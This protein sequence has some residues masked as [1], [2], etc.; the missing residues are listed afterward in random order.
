MTNNLAGMLTM[1]SWSL[2]VG[3]D[4]LRW[5]LALRQI[6]SGRTSPACFVPKAENLLVQ[7]VFRISYSVKNFE[8]SQNKNYLVLMECGNPEVTTITNTFPSALPYFFFR[9]ILEDSPPNKGNSS[10]FFFFFHVVLFF[11]FLI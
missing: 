7:I 6:V 8:L 1:L 2:H 10:V 3:H 11:F 4:L 9:I 5:S